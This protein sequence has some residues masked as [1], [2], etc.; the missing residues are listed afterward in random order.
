MISCK[1]KQVDST[2]LDA[3]PKK[4]RMPVQVSRAWDAYFSSGDPGVR[5]NLLNHYLPLVCN[6][7]G[8]MALGFP[9]AVELNDLIST[10]TIGLCQS[11]KNFDPKRGVKFE[12]FAVPRIRGAILDEMRSLDWVPRSTR[13]KARKIDRVTTQIEQQQGRVSMHNEL[14]V[15]LKIPLDDLLVVLTDI[16][17]SR[18]MSLDELVYRE[19]DNR[20]VPR[21]ETLELPVR[22]DALREVERR[23]LK[24]FLINAISTL[25]EQETH[26]IGLYYYDELTI[27]EIGELMNLSESRISQVH[28]RSVEKLRRMVRDRFGY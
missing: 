4:R 9:K 7:A 28:T 11:L 22:R 16:S 19:E 8:R 24:V 18:L 23:E 12:T 15:L 14:A 6:V 27:R 3:R 5:Q 2:R 13:S 17:A 21:V 1:S 20:Q 25:N 10:G 26:V